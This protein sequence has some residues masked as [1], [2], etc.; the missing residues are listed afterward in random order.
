MNYFSIKN[1]IPSRV[2]GEVKGQSEK[3]ISIKPIHYL[4]Q[5]QR[6][7]RESSRVENCVG[8]SFVCV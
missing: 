2:R 8:S 6:L 3:L 1:P 4:V 7:P 5:Q